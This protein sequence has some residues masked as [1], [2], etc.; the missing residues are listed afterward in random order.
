MFSDYPEAA[1][2]KPRVG[3]Y[4]NIS[5]EKVVS[6]DPD[7]S[8]GTADGNREE[9]VKQFERRQSNIPATPWRKLSPSSQK[10]SSSHR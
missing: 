9:I 5:I 7:L 3:S 10:S 6:L 1:R 2:S 4:V 8:I